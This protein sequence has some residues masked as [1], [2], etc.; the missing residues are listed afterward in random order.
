MPQ[1]THDPYPFRA[2]C[3]AT[4]CATIS[5]VLRA[6]PARHRILEPA[7]NPVK[8]LR[9]L[10]H[11]KR[12]RLPNALVE[13]LA[14]GMVKYIIVADARGSCDITFNSRG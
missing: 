5:I 4:A 1:R 8:N 6:I 3:A 13:T 11:R 9:R 7:V 14:T 2:N 10:L 12:Q